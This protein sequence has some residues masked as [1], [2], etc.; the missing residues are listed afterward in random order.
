MHAG[1]PAAAEKLIALD[2]ELAIAGFSR[3][4]AMFEHAAVSSFT[5]LDGEQWPGRAPHDGPVAEIVAYVI[6][7]RRRPA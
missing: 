5:T 2:I 6:E 7:A 3:L 4:A 1:A